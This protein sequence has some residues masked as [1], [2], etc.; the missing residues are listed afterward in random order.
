MPN[1][2]STFFTSKIEAS[3]VN[4]VTYSLIVGSLDCTDEMKTLP[5]IMRETDKVVSEN[6]NIKLVRSN[7]LVNSLS[8]QS[9]SWFR[10]PVSFSWGFVTASGTSD[11]VQ[12][13]SGNVSE[14]SIAKEAIEI[15]VVDKNNVFSKTIVK[16]VDYPGTSATNI[17]PSLI[18]WDLM[19][20][21]MGL[22]NVM[23]TSN[24]DIDYTS[25]KS[26]LDFENSE[27]YS[28]QV[29]LNRYYGETSQG[30]SVL[31]IQQIILKLASAAVTKDGAGRLVPFGWSQRTAEGSME[32]TDAEIIGDIESTFRDDQ[33]LN[34]IR[35]Q[36]YNILGTTTDGQYATYQN[37][38]SINSWGVHEEDYIS[39][40]IRL[41]DQSSVG[42]YVRWGSVSLAAYR[43]VTMADDPGELVRHKIKTNISGL[44]Y[45][46]EDA[47]TLIT[48]RDNLGSRD[49]TIRKIEYDLN[50]G[51]VEIE[52]IGRHIP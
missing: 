9:Y 27:P 7:A 11:T 26:W 38:S 49:L 48:S 51:K 52:L 10:Q 14:M 23:S 43:M 28:K 31:K 12:L 8:V 22:S 4:S 42:G 6:T 30:Q 17:N 50:S 21:K 33:M 5:R 37:S 39:T 25:W 36:F 32:I 2:F 41:C 35:L 24:P 34:K 3:V 47:I 45:L 20:L 19:T 29:I 44:K 16:S 15:N 18:W 1:S 13:L 46:P 40:Q